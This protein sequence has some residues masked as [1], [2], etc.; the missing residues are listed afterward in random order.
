MGIVSNIGG[1]F[2]RSAN[3]ERLNQWY[4]STLKLDNSGPVVRAFGLA[5]GEQPPRN[6]NFIVT[7]GV[8]DFDAVILGLKSEG[9][10]VEIFTGECATGRCARLHDPDGNPIELWESPATRDV[11]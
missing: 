10:P 6:R 4:E 5:P 8:V 7:F 1:L 9:V 3:P 2:I 11:A